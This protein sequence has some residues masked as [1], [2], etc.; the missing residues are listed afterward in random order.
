LTEAS[1]ENDRWLATR[2]GADHFPT[3]KIGIAQGAS[4]SQNGPLT[5][6]ADSLRSRGIE[7]SKPSLISALRN[8]DPEIRSL[9][10]L[11]LAEDHDSDTL[12]LIVRALSVEEVQTAR[13]GI[14]SA[15]WSLLGNPKGLAYLQRMCS[16]SSLS[17]NVIVDVV[18]TLNVVNKSSAQ[19]A[20]FIL[21]YLDSHDDSE[22]RL[23]LLR[24]LSAMYRWVPQDQA[25]RM[26]E[27]LQDMLGDKNPSIRMDAGHALVEISLG[28]STEAHRSAISREND[29]VV[30]SSLQRD[31]SVLQK[32]Q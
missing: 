7:I 11:K 20:G 1:D 18:H 25:G 12:P 6:F 10:A 28:S 5:P 30:R 13:T 4:D 23:S 26:A 21:G 14:S 29:P 3:G 2:D 15:L 17:I 16:D 24:A 27:M 22:S 9:A 31:L 32:E 19:C 8:P